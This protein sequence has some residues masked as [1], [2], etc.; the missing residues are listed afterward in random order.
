MSKKNQ[1]E[2]T[3]KKE[4]IF[5]K[6]VILIISGIILVAVMLIAEAFNNHSRAVEQYKDFHNKIRMSR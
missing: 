1:T 6:P 5:E 4:K 2:I 3:E